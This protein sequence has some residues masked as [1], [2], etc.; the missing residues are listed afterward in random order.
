MVKNSDLW[1][2]ILEK[3]RKC[4]AMRRSYWTVWYEKKILWFDYAFDG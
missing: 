4:S 2:A 1:V 3:S